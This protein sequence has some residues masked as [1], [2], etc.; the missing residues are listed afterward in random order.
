[1]N[2]IST[3]MPR[4]ESSISN[5]G[6]SY[7]L[8]ILHTFTPFSF[9][10]ANPSSLFFSKLNRSDFELFGSRIPRGSALTPVLDFFGTQGRRN[11]FSYS[12]EGV[13]RTLQG[14]PDAGFDELIPRIREDIPILPLFTW[15]H[16]VLLS[17]R[18][19][20][21]GGAPLNPDDSFRF[22]SLIRLN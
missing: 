1:M 9:P 10:T 19:R 7:W 20:L 18:V 2:L 17:K 14:R 22:L 13:D 12:D 16:G 21:S 8:R 4:Q 5:S 6:S 3:G 15:N 11:Y